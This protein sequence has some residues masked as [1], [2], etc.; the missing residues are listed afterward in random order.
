MSSLYPSAVVLAPFFV[1]LELLFEFG[2]FPSLHK[3]VR[4]G[5]GVEVAKF[6]RSNAEQK[7]AKEQKDE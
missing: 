4:N 3:D 1:H 2:W 6:R 5:I 7:R